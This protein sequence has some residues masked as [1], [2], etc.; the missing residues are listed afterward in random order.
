MEQ[1]HSTFNTRSRRSRKTV[2]TL[3][4][5]TQKFACKI[6]TK[7]WNRGHQESLGL[8]N[9]PDLVY[10]NQENDGQANFAIYISLLTTKV[11]SQMLLLYLVLLLTQFVLCIVCL[12]D[13]YFVEPVSTVTLSFLSVFGTTYLIMFCYLLMYVALKK[14]YM[15]IFYS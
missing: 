3:Q 2:W 7:N 1:Y 14:L 6:I 4:Q 13:I 10:Y 11:F 5:P 12:F 8:L 15:N 9:L